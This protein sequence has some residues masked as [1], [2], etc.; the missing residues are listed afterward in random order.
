MLKASLLVSGRVTVVVEPNENKIVACGIWFPPRHRLSIWK[1]STL[2]R[3]GVI[4]VLKRW[5]LTGL[6]VSER[7]LFSLMI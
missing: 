3:S 1:M 4:S 7:E 6:L 5:G 2:F